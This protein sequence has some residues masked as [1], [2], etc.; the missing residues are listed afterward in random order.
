MR[1]RG[2]EREEGEGPEEGE[3]LTC[4][5]STTRLMIKQLGVSEPRASS[6]FWGGG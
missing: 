4:V 6:F 1:S 5:G 3:G 2:W